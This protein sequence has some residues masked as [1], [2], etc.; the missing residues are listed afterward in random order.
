MALLYPTGLHDGPLFISTQV[1]LGVCMVLH[2]AAPRTAGA[3]SVVPLPP[4]PPGPQVELPSD[5]RGTGGDCDSACD[6]CGCDREQDVDR[7]GATS[8]DLN[9]DGT[10]GGGGTISHGK[11]PMASEEACC[12]Y[13]R[14]VPNAVIYK[15]ESDTGHNCWCSSNK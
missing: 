1:L 12:Q 4:L 11:G 14:A 13:C 15:W 9:P 6:V 7:G 5:R 8:H 3:Q 10:E 2:A